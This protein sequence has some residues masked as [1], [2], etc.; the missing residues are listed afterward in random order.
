V[1]RSGVVFVQAFDGRDVAR[2]ILRLADCAE[3][4]QSALLDAD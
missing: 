4:V 1:N 2:Y 3:R